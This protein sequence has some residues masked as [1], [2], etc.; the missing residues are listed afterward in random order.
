M[1]TIESVAT[2]IQK[3]LPIIV[4]VV[5]LTLN[6][7]FDELDCHKAGHPNGCHTMG[8][9]VLHRVLDL[10]LE[11]FSRSGP[12]P[13]RIDGREGSGEQEKKRE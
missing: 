10:V 6:Q 4:P 5:E 13:P 8:G 11:I 1:P 2:E 12:K 3:D 9:D 7:I